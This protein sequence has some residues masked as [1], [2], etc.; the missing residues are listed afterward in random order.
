MASGQRRLSSAPQG[1]LLGNAFYFCRDAYKAKGRKKIRPHL[2]A[3]QH[4][5]ARTSVTVVL[6]ARRHGS[7]PSQ[8][9]EWKDAGPELSRKVDM[10]APPTA[11]FSLFHRPPGICGL[12]APSSEPC[13]LGGADRYFHGFQQENAPLGRQPEEGRAGTSRGVWEGR[14]ALG[15]S[16]SSN[17]RAGAV[18]VPA[19]CHG[20]SPGGSLPSF[21]VVLL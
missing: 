4:V 2:A 11:G 13:S 5:P 3:E 18:W 19:S 1:N 10:G 15:N 12:H 20:P 17:G 14:A 9:D 16:S 21:E 6:V 7:S 8:A